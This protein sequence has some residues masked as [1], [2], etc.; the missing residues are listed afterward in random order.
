MN[1][2]KIL[3]SVTIILML[4]VIPGWTFVERSLPSGKI[5]T[6]SSEDQPMLCPYCGHYHSPTTPCPKK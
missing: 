4:P 2:L 6:A 5:E 1:K 3:G